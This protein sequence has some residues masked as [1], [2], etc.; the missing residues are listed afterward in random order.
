I[1]GNSIVDDRPSAARD[2][3]GLYFRSAVVTDIVDIVEDRRTFGTDLEFV[4]TYIFF[5]ARISGEGY[6]AAEQSLSSFAVTAERQVREGDRILLVYDE[7][8]GGYHFAGYVRINR[9]AV[10]GAVFFALM[11]L[12]GRKKGF[13][14]IISLGFTCAA[15]FWVFVPA[16]LSGRNI[17]ASAIVI[18]VY[19]IVSTMVLVLGFG[20]KAL[21]AVAGCLG[22]VVAAGVL[23]LL[24]DGVL[25]LTGMLN[26]EA[27][28][29]SFLPI[30]VPLDLQALVFAGVIIGATG[31]IMDAAM[32]V[33]SSVYEV[34]EAG[35]SDF[36]G[37]LRSGLNVGKDVLGANLNTFILAYIG[38]S[39]SLVLLVFATATSMAEF[40][41]M[42]MI[43]V[44]FLRVLVGSLGMLLTIPLT[45]AVCAKLCS[46]PQDPDSRDTDEYFY[47]DHFGY[48]RKD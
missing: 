39:L 20:R 37:L 38:S 42:E 6:V 41:N 24:M 48:I 36:K 35:L 31:V 15:I 46:K 10:L 18:C 17:Y 40:L 11:L 23:M 4:N 30:E 2:A 3:D 1:V 44:E 26:Q 33:A 43:A 21:G 14:A 9:I 16:I 32:S 27:Q 5:V 13:D 34:R 29:L 47:D 22:G 25:N 8:F 45:A 12:F 28:M 7:F 19:A